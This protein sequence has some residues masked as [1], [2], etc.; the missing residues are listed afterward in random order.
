MLQNKFTFS[1]ADLLKI[2]IHIY[3]DGVN[4]G[5]NARPGEY[6]NSPYFAKLYAE[7]MIDYIKRI[8]ISF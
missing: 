1:E 2:F 3:M 7:A 6:S 5:H 8:S 4:D